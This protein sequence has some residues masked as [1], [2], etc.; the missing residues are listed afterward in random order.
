MILLHSLDGTDQALL[1][2]MVSEVH[3]QVPSQSEYRYLE[4]MRRT[5]LRLE[6][7]E[8]VVTATSVLTGLPEYDDIQKSKILTL[9]LS[10]SVMSTVAY[11]DYN[12]AYLTDVRY[13]R[14]SQELSGGT[15]LLDMHNDLCFASDEVR[16]RLLTLLAHEAR[17]KVPPTFLAPAAEVLSCLNE[18]DIEVLR[19]RDFTIRC[20]FRLAWP[21]PELRTISVIDEV[22]GEPSIRLNFDEVRPS[23]DLEPEA[24]AAAADALANVRAAAMHVGSR[25]GHVL[26]KGEALMIFNDHCLH[27][28]GAFDGTDC[29]RLLLR[30]YAIERSRAASRRS[31]MLSLKD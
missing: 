11:W 31:S 21:H 15:E 26:L 6:R 2:E 12:G 4:A 10:E 3:A 20:G 17:G 9:L 27:G 28:R 8:G 18:R 24:H 1:R 16:P 23:A 14:G 5:G 25:N 13:S 7:L 30:A 19:R 22:G 29:S